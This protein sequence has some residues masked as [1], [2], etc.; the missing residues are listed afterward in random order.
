MNIYLDIDGVL[1][2]DNPD[3]AGAPTKH[4]IEFLKYLTTHHQ[5]FWLTTHC[6]NGENQA[7]SYLI[8]KIPEASTYINKILPA[9]WSKWKTEAI[10]FQEDFR[11]IDD[12][13]YQPEINDLQSNNSQHKS[14]KINL[15]KNPSQLK[16]LVDNNLYLEHAKNLKYVSFD[17]RAEVM[18][19]SINMQLPAII[20]QGQK[21][22]IIII[23][24]PG[25][26]G[27]IDG[28]N[29]K[30]AK[31]ANLITEQNLGTVIRLSNERP[32]GTALETTLQEVLIHAIEYA[33]SI[34]YELTGSNTP[35]I[36]LMGTSAGASAIAVIA[37]LY[38]EIK[39]I[40]LIAPSLNAGVD[41]IK[42]GLQNYLN[43]VYITVGDD[44]EHVGL[45]AASAMIQYAI[46]ASKKELIIIPNCDHHFKGKV[47][48]LIL[49]TAPLWAFN[50]DLAYPNSKNGIELY[51]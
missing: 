40:L 7:T 13:I 21:N 19:K 39:K 18:S 29:Y 4:A 31:I 38:T 24:Y 25:A 51:D 27:N 22:G 8:S 5:V 17:F 43:E 32:L 2:D 49:S 15:R 11:W 46:Q 28:Y 6:M 9:Q 1:L 47:N 14:I 41:G 10:E 3:N 33:L 30:Y 16:D 37:S 20:H 36:Y 12:E 44:D 35:Q 42:H 26:N 34:S 50:G 48:G 23:N 45:E